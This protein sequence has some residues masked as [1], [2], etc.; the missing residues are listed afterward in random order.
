MQ[1][2][3]IGLERTATDLELRETGRS[4]TVTNQIL[5]KDLAN[6]MLKWH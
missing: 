5:E 4:D 1:T 3:M 2:I 6:Q